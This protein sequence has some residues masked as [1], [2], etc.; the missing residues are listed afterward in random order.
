M[1]FFLGDALNLQG[2]LF[3]LRHDEH[4]FVS[5]TGIDMKAR[6]VFVQHLS[7]VSSFSSSRSY[8]LIPKNFC[9]ERREYTYSGGTIK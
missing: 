9:T 2:F 8:P 1:V 5:V 6:L 3:S 7:G 4:E